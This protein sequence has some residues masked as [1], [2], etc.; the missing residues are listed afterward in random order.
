MNIITEIANELFAYGQVSIESLIQAS[1]Y[2]KTALEEQ[3][4]SGLGMLYHRAG[5]ASQEDLVS[6]RSELEIQIRTNTK[7]KKHRRRG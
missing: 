5:L 7:T 2:S 4:M 6:L 3:T 1:K